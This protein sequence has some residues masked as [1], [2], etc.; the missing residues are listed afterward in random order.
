MCVSVKAMCANFCY[1]AARVNGAVAVD[2]IMIADAA[3][4]SGSMPS[5]NVLDGVV[6][7]LWG[8]GTMNDD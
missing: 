7:P 5:V 4:A 1:R 3:E 8:G 2:Y 6:L